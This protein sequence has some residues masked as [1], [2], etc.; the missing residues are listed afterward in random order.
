[1]RQQET[2]RTQEDIMTGNSC[3][4]ASVIIFDLA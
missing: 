2:G 3:V 4:M 1:M